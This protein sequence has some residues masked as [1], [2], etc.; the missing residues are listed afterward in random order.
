MP[1]D[2]GDGADT[3]T[4][5]LN[6]TVCPAHTACTARRQRPGPSAATRSASRPTLDTDA[7]RG[8]PKPQRTTAKQRPTQQHS[9]DLTGPAPSGMTLKGCHVRKPSRRR[10]GTPTGAVVAVSVSTCRRPS[11]LGSSTVRRPPAASH[12]MDS[13]AWTRP[14]DRAERPPVEGNGVDR[15]DSRPSPRLGQLR[16]RTARG[17]DVQ[18]CPSSEP[19]VRQG[20]RGGV[21]I[22]LAVGSQLAVVHA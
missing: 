5:R 15:S 6:I 11:L 18:G 21:A 3:H 22:R 8:A 19:R 17:V 4:Q 1:S 12:V 13:P 7:S 14:P 9:Q 16:M 20:A 2:L 10:A